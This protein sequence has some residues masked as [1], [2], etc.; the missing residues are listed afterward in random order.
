MIDNKWVALG[1]TDGMDENKV[2]KLV[3]LYEDVAN[4]LI[5]DVEEGTFDTMA[6]PITY[7]VVRDTD[8]DDIVTAEEIITTIKDNFEKLVSQIHQVPGVDAEAEAAAQVAEIIIENIKN[9]TK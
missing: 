2:P 3:G 5:A 7:R 6:F 4:I 9:K 8:L 1:L